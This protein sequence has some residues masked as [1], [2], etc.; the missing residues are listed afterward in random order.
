[1]LQAQYNI[2]LNILINQK[3]NLIDLLKSNNKD[4]AKFN[5]IMN[6]I[7]SIDKYKISNDNFNNNEINNEQNHFNVTEVT[8]TKKNIKNSQ[9]NK[10]TKLQYNK[11]ILFSIEL[12]DDIVNK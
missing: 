6:D 9:E 1:M 10:N 7:F 12:N 8:T 4:S 11:K 5:E 2:T 3:K